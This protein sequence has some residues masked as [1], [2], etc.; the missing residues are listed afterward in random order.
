MDRTPPM[1]SIDGHGPKPDAYRLPIALPAPGEIVGLLG[2]THLE[3]SA[4]VDRWLMVN[5]VIPTNGHRRGSYGYL[6]HDYAY[7]DDVTVYDVLVAPAGDDIRHL[8]Q[9]IERAWLHD[10]LGHRVSRLPASVKL[11]VGL[12]RL[13]IEHPRIVILEEPLAGIDR[14]LH[15]SIWSLVEH[16]TAQQCRVVVISQALDLADRCS[17]VVLLSHGQLIADGAPDVVRS[18]AFG[19]SLLLVEV[20]GLNRSLTSRILRLPY[21]RGGIR[22]SHW[23]L[24]LVVDDEFTSSMRLERD[25]RRNENLPVT[26]TPY[27]VPFDRVFEVLTT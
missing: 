8:Q 3:V 13:I 6:T 20:P 26:I 17:R 15:D 27:R 7:P 14:M 11:R 23:L 19:G 4:I 9:T 16:L 21:V 1:T 24:E 25:I 22:L 5:S 10:V 2:S 18:R 12:A